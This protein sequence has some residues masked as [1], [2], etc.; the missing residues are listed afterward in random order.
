MSKLSL[1]CQKSM[2]Q[3]V[4]CRETWPSQD[5][6]SARKA[7]LYSA[8]N[9]AKLI[10]ATAW[11]HID[12]VDTAF[13]RVVVTLGWCFN[14]LR[15]LVFCNAYLLHASHRS[16]TC[17]CVAQI[18]VSIYNSFITWFHVKPRPFCSVLTC[19][20][21]VFSSHCTLQKPKTSALH[22]SRTMQSFCIPKWGIG[23]TVLPSRT[24]ALFINNSVSSDVTF[25][26]F[27]GGLPKDRLRALW[28]P[29]PAPEFWKESSLIQSGVLS[30]FWAGLLSGHPAW[31]QQL[32]CNLL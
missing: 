18:A 32:P 14:W 29:V 5:V 26:C 17:I 23:G 10:T 8:I 22:W 16:Q 1:F 30:L 27:L 2:H 25:A 21:F 12:L 19:T 11:S 7:K 31:G 3:Q 28:H 24:S 15:V 4:Y 20:L 9:L 6:W 13:A